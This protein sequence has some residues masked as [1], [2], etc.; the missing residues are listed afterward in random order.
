MDEG[1][2]GDKDRVLRE[3]G[4]GGLYLMIDI[5]ALDQVV[6]VGLEGIR[7]FIAVAALQ[8]HRETDG[9]VICQLMDGDGCVFLA[10]LS[11]FDQRMIRCHGGYVGALCQ[12]SECI[13]VFR[14]G[15]GNKA[16]TDIDDVMVN[17]PFATVVGMG[18]TFDADVGIELDEGFGDTAEKYLMFDIADADDFFIGGPA[19]LLDELL[20]FPEKVRGSAIERFAGWSQCETGMGT[21]KEAAA[22]FGF[23]MIDLLEHSLTAHIERIFGFGKA[24]AV[25]CGDKDADLILIHWC[26]PFV[27][28]MVAL[29]S[30]LRMKAGPR[31]FAAK[32]GE[33]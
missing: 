10:S 2:G 17:A 3:A 27:T 11:L 7:Q 9:F 22:D 14:H 4:V 13:L 21:D 32:R 8:H 31:M 26:Q 23:K 6:G 28:T 29:S 16:F 25:C 5:L 19:A 30:F 24:A 18:D 15:V 1:V 12:F 20:L 33:L